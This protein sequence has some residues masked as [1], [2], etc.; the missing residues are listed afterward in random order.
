MC[1]S[2]VG[3]R[4][5]Q[6]A[7][8]AALALGGCGGS[9]DVAPRLIP[10]GGIGDGS[11]DGKVNVYV[12]DDDTDAPIAGAAVTVGAVEG[13]TD[14]TG[15][16]VATGDVHGAQTI[17]A[18]ASGHVASMWVGAD[19]VNVTIPLAS[20]AADTGD[21][22]QAQITGTITGWADLQPTAGRYLAAF[23]GYTQTRQIGARENSLTQPTGTP[24][25]NVCLNAGG[26]IP[27][28]CN[29]TLRS[30]T[31][32]VAVHA[33]LFEGDPHGTP[34]DP[35]DDTY[36][37]TGFGW[38][39]GLVVQDGV[40]QSGVAIDLLGG[41]AIVGVNVDLGTPPPGL[42][43]KIAVVG[44]DLGDDGIAQMANLFDATQIVVP[45]LS[46]LPAGA[47]YRLNAFC[48][49]PGAGLDKA[50]SLVFQRDLATPQFA[51]AGWL[52][53]PGG[54]AASAASVAFN[55]V[56]GA[57]LHTIELA[58]DAGRA[59]S[60]AIFD[61]SA[62]VDLPAQ[63]ALPAGTI[64]VDVG[65]IEADLDVHDFSLAEDA[66]QIDRLASDGVAFSH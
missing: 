23:V 14:A 36:T 31:G 12:I 41:D 32:H 2:I 46:A 39:G 8:A 58:G 48:T 38:K 54:L 63:V 29:W 43:D 5:R 52:A 49:E 25:P 40:D 33:V 37:M 7:L 60:I 20:T 15:L 55:R 57:A 59:L 24:P 4:T 28:T 6:A 17:V 18:T 44:V 16:F 64:H 9:S 53:P 22:P 11:P 30:R 21:V 56:A 66:E 10:G 34:L 62:T 35:S 42:T 19:G 51:V 26:P 13:T 3:M 45:A 50:Q 61:D 1:R 27:A 47:S 65:A